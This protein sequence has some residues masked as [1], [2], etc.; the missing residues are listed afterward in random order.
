MNALEHRKAPIYFGAH[1]RRTSMLE[2]LL[3]H[4][5]DANGCNEYGDTAL[6]EASLRGDREIVAL[7]LENGAKVDVSNSSGTALH[8]ACREVH[9]DVVEILIAYGADVNSK[10]AYDDDDVQH[11]PLD[12]ALEYGHYKVV[13]KLTSRGANVSNVIRRINYLPRAAENGW[14]EIVDFLVTHGEDINATVFWEPN[15]PPYSHKH[16]AEFLIQEGADVNVVARLRR[17]K[18][19][20][21]FTT[22]YVAIMKGYEDIVELLVTNG[23]DVNARGKVIRLDSYDHPNLSGDDST[24]VDDPESGDNS[25]PGDD[26]GPDNAGPDND[27]GC[28][29]SEVD[30]PNGELQEYGSTP[31][32]PDD[33]DIDRCDQSSLWIATMRE[34]RNMVS[35]LVEHG[36]VMDPVG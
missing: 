8:N 6:M 32:D 20:Y 5:A 9:V 10:T 31:S 7:L 30:F 15:S 26:S 4:G 19:L 23:A 17:G 27:L 18:N 12:H 28:G 21:Y 3:A 11:F 22:L 35:M 14:A 24:Q 29:G 36:A 13:R 16:I 34:Q 33:S 1:E 25:D 2:H